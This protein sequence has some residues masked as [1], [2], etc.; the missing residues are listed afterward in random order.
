MGRAY[1]QARLGSSLFVDACEAREAERALQVDQRLTTRCVADVLTINAQLPTGQRVYLGHGLWRR[2]SHWCPPRDTRARMEPHQCLHGGAVPTGL[3]REGAVPTVPGVAALQIGTALHERVSKHRPTGCRVQ[4]RTCLSVAA[5][6]YWQDG[7][8]TG[9]RQASSSVPLPLI[10]LAIPR[11]CED[12]RGAVCVQNVAI[13]DDVSRPATGLGGVAIYK[14][15][16][17]QQAG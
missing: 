1:R 9:S 16:I 8:T 12:R 6:S 14:F 3:L 5:P 2:R 10:D 11:S 13:I 15:V 7:S 4:A 17:I